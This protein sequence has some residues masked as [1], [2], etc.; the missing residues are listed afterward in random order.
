METLVKMAPRFDADTQRWVPSTDDE[1]AEASADED[2]GEADADSEDKDE[3]KPRAKAERR[4]RG[5]R[6]SRGTSIT[7]RYKIQEV[8]R[9][10]QVLLVQVVKEERGQKVNDLVQRHPNVPFGRK[11]VY[12]S[13]VVV[14]RVEAAGIIGSSRVVIVVTT[15]H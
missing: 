5:A 7:R 10:R 4:R 3:K 9:R 6:K 13:V 1:S 14:G 8:I 15:H 11:D 12:P 2:S